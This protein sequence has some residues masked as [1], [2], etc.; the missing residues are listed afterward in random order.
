MMLQIPRFNTVLNNAAREYYLP[1]TNTL[2]AL[3]QETMKEKIVDANVQQSFTLAATLALASRLPMSKVLCVGSF[4]DTACESLVAMGYRID[5]MDPDVNG[6]DLDGFVR[7][8]PDK[9]GTYDVIFSTSVIEHVEQD[10]RFAAEIARLLKP[11][12]Y[13]LLTCDY[14]NDWRAG[15]PKPYEDFRFYTADDLGERLPAAMSGCRLIDEP[16]WAQH[17]PDFTYANCRYSFATFAVQKVE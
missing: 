7:A 3:A 4:K 6:M 8:N 15:D 10:D 12:G 11:G 5:Q 2:W 13:A 14:R 16:D 1:A 17:A 9:I